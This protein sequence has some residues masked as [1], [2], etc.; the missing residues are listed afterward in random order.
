MTTTGSNRICCRPFSRGVML[1]LT[2]STLFF[3][4][5]W[6]LFASIGSLLPENNIRFGFNC[7]HCIFWLLLPMTGWVAESWL[8]RYRAIVV[9]LLITTVAILAF[10]ATFVMLNFDAIVI[11]AFSLVIVALAL[12]T[13]GIGSFYTNALPFT[14]DQ[15][16]GASAEELSAVVQWYW[17]GSN[18]GIL[19]QSIFHCVPIPRQLQFL[20]ILPV[21]FLS[22]GSL[23]LST[24][25]IMDCLC[26]KWLDTNDKTGNPIKLIF[27][28]LNYARNNK[29]PRLRSAFTY[30]DEE[31]PSRLDFGKHKFGGSFTEEE[32][33]DVKTIFRITP[34]LVA[35]F[36]PGLVFFEMYN[37]FDLHAT[38]T[39]TA[40]FECVS[41]GLKVNIISIVPLFLVPV[42]R[43]TF[44]FISKYIPSMLKVMGIGIFLCLASTV[45]K[46]AV[47]SIGHFYSNA[48]HCIFDEK[49]DTG[50]ILIPLYWVLIIELINGVGFTMTMC[51]LFEFVMA[52]TPNRMRGIMMGLLL[53][54]AGLAGLSIMLLATLFQYFPTATPSCVFYYYLVLSLLMLLILVVYVVLARRYKLRERE[55]H[56]NMQAIVEEHYERYFDQ[57]EEYLREN[58]KLAHETVVHVTEVTQ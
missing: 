38:P 56:V 14:L 40:T 26:H 47:D 42:Y 34:L 54:I 25:L 23:S 27:R 41:V 18:A 22:L 9:G 15:M 51:T 1:V 11:P 53:M 57:E 44:P 29:Y 16:I 19:I 58:A 10:Q 2:Y 32:V 5:H 20:D 43:F 46:L 39:T 55:R 35:V 36:V 21:V 45:I 7:A 12:G 3:A 31:Q 8:G 13:I 52:Q 17:W 50:T 28:V 24:A 49:A 37:Q 30:I 4:V 33:E 48:S 6:F